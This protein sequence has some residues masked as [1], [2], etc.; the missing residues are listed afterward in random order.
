MFIW[1]HKKPQQAVNKKPHI[2]ENSTKIG[3]LIKAHKGH[4]YVCEGRR[5]NQTST[6]SAYL[7]FRS[8]KSRK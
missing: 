5:G 3:Y 8:N 1:L 6:K 4:T 7:S 2:L